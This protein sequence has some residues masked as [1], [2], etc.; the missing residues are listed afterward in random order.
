MFCLHLAHLR[1]LKSLLA[2][3]RSCATLQAESEAFSSFVVLPGYLPAAAIR[4]DRR[5]GSE[6]PA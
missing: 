2:T 3:G 4:S 1:S 5:N 6:D